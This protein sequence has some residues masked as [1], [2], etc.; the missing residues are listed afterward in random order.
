MRNKNMIQL[1]KMI[2]LSK[3]DKLVEPV[4][5]VQLDKT[6]VTRENGLIT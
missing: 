4:E 6:G 2:P 5:I 1:V 3:M